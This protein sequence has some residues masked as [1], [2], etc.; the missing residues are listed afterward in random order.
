LRRFD[1]L[2]TWVNH[3]WKEVI[4]DGDFK[5][6]EYIYHKIIYITKYEKLNIY[7]KS[8]IVGGIFG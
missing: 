3:C 5:I 1:Y 4:N 6:Y 7:F 2:G 8:G